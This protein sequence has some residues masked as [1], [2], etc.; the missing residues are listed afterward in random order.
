[1]NISIPLISLVSNLTPIQASMP[2]ENTELQ[3]QL[4]SKEELVQIV[5]DKQKKNINLEQFVLVLPALQLYKDQDIKVVKQQGKLQKGQSH[6][7]K[8][9]EI[10]NTEE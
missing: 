9:S 4:L 5:S 8:I 2:I 3:K 1:M 7:A 10:T 6:T